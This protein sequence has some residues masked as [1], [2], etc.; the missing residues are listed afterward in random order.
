MAVLREGAT[1]TE[2]AI[3]ARFEGNPARFKHRRRTVF[4]ATLLR[5]A[6]GKV[7]KNLLRETYKELYR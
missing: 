3:R 6:L 1:L 7:Q 4:R 2:A 5:N